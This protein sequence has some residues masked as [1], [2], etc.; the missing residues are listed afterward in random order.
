MLLLLC[1]CAMDG[2]RCCV[3]GTSC[4][5]VVLHLDLDAFY[6]QV[7][8]RR[9]NIEREKPLAVRQWE[10]LIAVNYPARAKG[11]GRFCNI[12]QAREKC[13]DLVLVHVETI[14]NTTDGGIGE[15]KPNRT[16]TKVSLQRYRK[17]ESQTFAY[18]RPPPHGSP[19]LEM[20]SRPP[21]PH[22]FRAY[23]GDKVGKASDF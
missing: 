21:A 17:G 9:L 3:G 15:V 14:G 22:I 16:T 23:L 2:H 12:E 11:V 19:P 7:E 8:H 10:G 20:W 18:S 5:R 6:C 4:W 13:P 1:V